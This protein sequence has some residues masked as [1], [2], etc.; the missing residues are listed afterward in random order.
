MSEFFQKWHKA[1]VTVWEPTKLQLTAEGL[2]WIFPVS[3]IL[4]R[5]IYMTYYYAPM[6]LNHDFLVSHAVLAYNNSPQFTTR[7]ELEISV[8]CHDGYTSGHPYNQ[9]DFTIFFV[10]VVKWKPKKK[11]PKSLFCTPESCKCRSVASCPESD[12]VTEGGASISTSDLGR[13][14]L[15]GGLW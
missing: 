8:K 15:C 14:Y 1:L 7:M 13:E 5:L 12:C 9:S 6:Y 10:G 11:N 3:P 4:F 2:T